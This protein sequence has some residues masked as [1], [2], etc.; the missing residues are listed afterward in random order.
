MATIGG[1]TLSSEN[2]RRLMFPNSLLKYGCEQQK[3]FLNHFRWWPVSKYLNSVEVF[4]VRE[5]VQQ[6]TVADEIQTWEEESLG[7]QVVL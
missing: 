6:F 7:F 4:R 3:Q 2:S 1:D 5:N